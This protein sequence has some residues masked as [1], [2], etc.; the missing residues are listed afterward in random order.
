[1]HKPNLPKLLQ[2][3]SLTSNS[4]KTTEKTALF[5]LSPLSSY[6]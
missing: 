1:M 2:N 6:T 5:A 3:F 4:E